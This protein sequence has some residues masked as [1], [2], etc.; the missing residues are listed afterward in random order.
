M[1]KLQKTNNINWK[2]NKIKRKYKKTNRKYQKINRKNQK[3]LTV[4][5]VLKICL[6]VNQSKINNQKRNIIKKIKEEEIQ[7]RKDRM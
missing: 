7:R 3:M 1:R 2:N 5:Q 4:K 6:K